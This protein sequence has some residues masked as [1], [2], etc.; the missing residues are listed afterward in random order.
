MVRADQEAVPVLQESRDGVLW[1]NSS[2]TGLR[3]HLRVG[4]L[5][6][7]DSLGRKR[8]GQQRDLGQGSGAEEIT[9]SVDS[10][11]QELG[12]TRMLTVRTWS[13]RV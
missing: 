13:L 8:T 3:C 10:D 6:Y 12:R 9:N 11:C 1:W 2:Q 7:R 5:R 4:F